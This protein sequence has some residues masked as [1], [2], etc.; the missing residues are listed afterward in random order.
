MSP[1]KKAC[2]VQ[3]PQ[4]ALQSINAPTF[5]ILILKITVKTMKF[6][7]L[8]QFEPILKLKYPPKESRPNLGPSERLMQ[9]IILLLTPGAYSWNDTV[10]IIACSETLS[11]VSQLNENHT[12]KK[13]FHESVDHSIPRVEETKTVGNFLQWCYDS[14]PEHVIHFYTSS[15]SLG[16]L[17]FEGSRDGDWI[18]LRNRNFRG[19]FLERVA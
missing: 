4:K 6:S 11:H 5:I 1:I 16:F 17:Y 2:H 8:F 9:N 13:D 14:L 18:K 10:R 12:T 3:A 7:I 19:T 15:S